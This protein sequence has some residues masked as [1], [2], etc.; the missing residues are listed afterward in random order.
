MNGIH[1][2]P[3]VVSNE[4]K[5]F[6]M[7][8]AGYQNIPDKLIE[9]LKTKAFTIT[10]A[11]TASEAQELYDAERVKGIICFPAELT[12]NMMIKTSD[13]SYVLPDKIKLAIADSDPLTRIF[14]LSA[15]AKS[16]SSA[17]E[18]AGGVIS[19]DS[20]PIPIDIEEL[21]A[22]FS[23][24][25]AYVFSALFGFICYVLTGIFALGTVVA[26]RSE[27]R[28]M[29]AMTKP[30]DL[31][32]FVL[33][34]GTTGYALYLALVSTVFSILGVAIEASLYTGSLLVFVLLCTGPAIAAAVATNAPDARKA[35]RPIIPYLILPLFLGG[36]LLPAELMPTWLQW[37]KFIFP[38]YYGLNAALAIELQE[39]TRFLPWSILIACIW[40]LFFTVLGLIGLKKNQS[41]ALTP[42]A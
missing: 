18:E 27:K 19:T 7:P 4:D 1:G 26:L 33:A 6:D 11:S 31:L 32:S 3:I 34:F 23:P 40:P 41:M 24:A 30:A 25:T 15:I 14:V 20:I 17:I 42:Q 21:A 2:Y 38:P 28:R 37:I 9:A 12:E 8:M 35:R 36:F 39:S 13:P 29:T 5:G 22:G 16:C 10:T